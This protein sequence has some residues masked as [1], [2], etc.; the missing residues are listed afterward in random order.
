MKPDPHKNM[1]LTGHKPRKRFGQNFLRDPHVI[2]KILS[3]IHANP[4]DNLV[5]IG[6]GLG[7][8][9]KP[10]LEQ[11]NHLDVVEIDRDLA[12]QLDTAF[13]HTQ[14][15]SVHT[16]DVLQFDFTILKKK[17]MRIVGNLPYNI[18]TPLI[19]Y[20]LNF[21]NS[22]QDMHFM[23]Q[24]EVVDR[25]CAEPDS[26]DYGRL[27]IMTQ[28]H[29]EA[30][31]LFS[32]PPSAFYPEP[33]VQSAFVRLIPRPFSTPATNVKL[34][35]SITRDA[36]NQRRKTLSNALKAYLNTEDFINLNISATLR[37]EVLSVTD[38]VKISNY[39]DQ[40]RNP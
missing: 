3:A 39:I 21:Q 16:Q 24:K 13:A 33:K 40:R 1:I 18:T 31:Y 4:E 26:K 9:T 15:L 19:F 30:A 12:S 22:I 7:V 38:F 8:L 36:F 14:K 29:C 35:E 32:V 25:I 11:V 6:P 28:Y 5:E 2:Q 34:L 27:S 37:P 10:L 20:L 17:N 23:L